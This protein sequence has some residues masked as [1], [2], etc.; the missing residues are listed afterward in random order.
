MRFFCS[1]LTK[2]G[3]IEIPQLRAVPK[4]LKASVDMKVAIIGT[5][6]APGNIATTILR[7]L[8]ENVTEIVSGGAA[9]VD[10]AA[11]EVAGILSLPVRRF[12][13]D[14]RRYGSRAPLCR[15]IQIVEYA[16]RVIA[17]WDGKSRGTRHC[18]I[19]CIN[20]RK[21]VRIIRINAGK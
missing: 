10:K 12:L 18:I 3:F 6:T 14:Y 5:R 21:P 19:E 16:D 4:N 2:T 17:F 7:S 20:R 15:N 11:E 13:P 9:G 8:P 1:I